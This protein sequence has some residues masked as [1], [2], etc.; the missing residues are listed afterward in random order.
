M[1]KPKSGSG[2]LRD[3]GGD[4]GNHISEWLGH[5]IY[6]AVKLDV[7]AFTGSDFGSCPFLTEALGQ[8]TSCVKGENSLGVC[9]VGSVSNGSLQDWLVC[10]YRVVSSDIVGQ[11]CRL[12]FGQT[13][14]DKYPRPVTVLK[15]EGELSKFK[16]QVAN[17]GTGYVF[18]QDKLGGEISVI[19]TPRSPEMSF[20]ITLVEIVHGATGFAVGRYGILEVQTMDFHGSYRRAVQNL[21]DALRLHAESFAESLREN[22]QWS[23][24]SIEGPNI[25]NVF[26][27][28]FYQVLLKFQLSGRG[29][30][31]G[32]VLA[33]PQSVWDSWQPF[34]GAPE[35]E[36]DASGSYRFRIT[37]PVPESS[38]S[39]N[40]HILV[41]DLDSS[42][43]T[44]ISPVQLRMDIRVTAEQLS[45]HAFKVVPAAVLES[46]SKSDSI[47][48]RIKMRLAS[49]WPELR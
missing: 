31:A 34:L 42:A 46:L 48:A 13:A 35:I 7:A 21:R 38:G 39:A 12:I 8:K 19:A 32:T 26:K 22:M 11:A 2:Q 44:A 29:A 1:P 17:D 23:A 14:V 6:P 27:R 25:A 43:G 10:P 15:T 30:A 36:R 24:Q 47:L 37:D 9:S 33:V 49:S 3:G 41:F 40:A 28:T 18:F 45:H 16:Q 20:D 4:A 5:R